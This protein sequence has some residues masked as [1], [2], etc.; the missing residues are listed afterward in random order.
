MCNPVSFSALTTFSGLNQI[1]F[2][3]SIKK[4]TCKKTINIKNVA[5][6][7]GVLGDN[8]ICI[9]WDRSATGVYKIKK[10]QKYWQS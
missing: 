9:Q 8:L 2:W 4:Q 5:V 10:K 3:F 6:L 7:C 1:F